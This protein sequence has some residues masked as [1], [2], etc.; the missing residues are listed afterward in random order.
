MFEKVRGNDV[1]WRFKIQCLLLPLKFVGVEMG[2]EAV[3][4][5]DGEPVRT[6]TLKLP[7]HSILRKVPWIR[8][9]GTRA[10]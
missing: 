6:E 1:L 4:S 7:W 5:V 9:Y 2:N 3:L 10:Y 8:Y